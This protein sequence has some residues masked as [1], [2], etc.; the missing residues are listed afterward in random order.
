M[1]LNAEIGRTITRAT[2]KAKGRCLPP[3]EQTRILPEIAPAVTGN[4]ATLATS[5]C[6][7]KTVGT[8][9]ETVSVTFI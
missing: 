8:S 6:C 3:I 1:A 2:R 4:P 5:K 9:K 7:S